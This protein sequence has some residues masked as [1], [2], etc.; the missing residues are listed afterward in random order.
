VDEAFAR[1]MHFAIEFPFPEE[2]DRYQ[3]WQRIFPPEAPL[4]DDV[5]LAF[6]ARQFRVTGGNIKN[7]AVTAAFLAAAGP[8]IITMEH[9][10]K[11]TKRE[12]QKM[13][14][15]CTETDFAK[16]FDLVKS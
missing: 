5:D 12:Y 9:I 11:S 15:L 3:I 2:H 16:Y 1:R 4:G 8:G 13:G 6:L 7:I 14:K 10:I